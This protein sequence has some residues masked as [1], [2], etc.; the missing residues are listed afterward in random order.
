MKKNINFLKK[1]KT[2]PQMFFFI[3]L[4]FFIIGILLVVLFPN[5]PEFIMTLPYTLILVGFL[6]AF[7]FSPLLWLLH[8]VE[9]RRLSKYD[10]IEYKN[11]LY[12]KYNNNMSKNIPVYMEAINKLNKG[13]NPKVVDEWVNRVNT[14]WNKKID[15]YYI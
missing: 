2:Y 3:G 5:S 13:I 15:D 14:A 1:I 11:S 8:K 4:P 6:F 9:K 10:N 7:M 12:N